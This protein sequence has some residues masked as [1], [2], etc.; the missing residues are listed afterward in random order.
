[1]NLY[2]FD[3]ENKHGQYLIFTSKAAALAWGRAATRLSDPE[4][5]A[6][7]RK[8]TKSGAYYNLFTGGK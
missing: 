2:A 1:M 7:I 5:L 6:H 3:T 4:I 8:L